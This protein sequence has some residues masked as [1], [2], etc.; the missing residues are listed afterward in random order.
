MADCSRA[1]VLCGAD[2]Q[3]NAKLSSRIGVK[4]QSWLP[5]ASGQLYERGME[6]CCSS[7]LSP[8]QRAPSDLS[9]SSTFPKASRSFKLL[10][11][12]LEGLTE[13]ASPQ[14]PESQSLTV[15]Q[16]FLVS[17]PINHQSPKQWG[18][19]FPEQIP[20][21]RWARFLKMYPL[22]TSFLSFPLWA[23]AG[24]G[25][26]AWVITALPLY[27]SQCGPL[28]L[29]VCDRKKMMIK[30]RGKLINLHMY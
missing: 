28:L 22:P 8:L 26:G 23:G 25:L 16:L 9:T 15:F 11:W 30:I 29:Q 4:F 12:V 6:R 13:H 14:W 17:S 1:N 7:T 3:G 27:P 2:R 24:E 10:W 21:A 18:L 5:Q 19:I 20:K